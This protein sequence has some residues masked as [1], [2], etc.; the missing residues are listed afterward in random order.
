[1]KIVIDGLMNNTDGMSLEQLT[2]LMSELERARDGIEEQLQTA[3]LKKWETGVAADPVWFGRAKGAL[4]RKNSEIEKLRVIVA[5]K[6]RAQRMAQANERKLSDYFV[7]ICKERMPP[8]LYEGILREALR[9]KL[10][11]QEKAALGDAAPDRVFQFATDGDDG[12]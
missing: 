5:D 4:K 9:R 3:A 6:R 12:P 7:G 10:L 1:M 8:E 2:Q 11:D